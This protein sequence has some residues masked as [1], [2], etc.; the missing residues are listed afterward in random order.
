[1]TSTKFGNNHFA[2]GHFKLV[3]DGKPVTAF[4]KGVEGGLVN[5]QAVE[6]PVGQ[7]NLRGRHLATR[8]I[9]PIQIEF[10]MSG[11]KWV[12]DFVDEFISKRKHHRISGEVI[13]ADTN[14]IAQYFYS[15]TNALITEMTLPKLDAAGKDTLMVKVKLQPEDVKFNLGDGRKLD[16]DPPGRQKAWHTSNFRINFDNGCNADYV[17]SIEP[18]TYK[19]GHKT[20]QLGDLF[21]P[22]IIPTKVEMPKL[23]ITM[24]LLR[25][26]AFIKWYQQSVANM[27]AGGTADAEGLGSAKNSGG[28]ETSVSIEYLDATF[29]KTLYEVELYGVGMEKFSIPKSEANAAAVK[30]GKF[31][32]YVTSSK[33]KTNGSGFEK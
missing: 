23:S 32:F 4:I 24:P 26:G 21:R 3:I 31:D 13:H 25:A 30:M 12:L 22:D 6:E 15:F 29:K 18:L 14:M 5:A 16:Q 1:M 33:V 28:Y 27:Q 10:G 8:E 20:M 7:Y 9:E 19:L 2:T 17:S 11:S